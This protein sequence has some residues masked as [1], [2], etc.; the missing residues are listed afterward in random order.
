[1][2]RVELETRR[3]QGIVLYYVDDEWDN[4]E[5]C[6]LNLE[7]HFHIETER[8]SEKALAAIEGGKEI[9]VLLTDQVMPKVTGMQLAEAMKR[10]NPLVPCIMITGHATKDLAIGAIKGRLFYD[11]LEKPVDFSTRGIRNILTSAIQEFLL[12]KLR[13]EY[14]TGSVNLLAR[15]IDERDGYTHEHSQRVMILSRQ[16]A[17]KFDLP[18]KDVLRLSQAALLHDVGKIGIPDSVLRKEGKLSSLEKDVMN[19]HPERGARLV[20]QIEQLKEIADIIRYH[21]ECP[22]GSGYPYGLKG[23]RIPLLSAIVHAC[24]FFDAL[25]SDRPYKKGWPVDQIV[26]EMQAQRDQK[27]NGEVLDAFYAVMIDEKMLDDNGIRAALDQASKL[28]RQ[29]ENFGRLETTTK[30]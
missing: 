14:E 19:S 30:H 9:H 2:D 29:D 1:M 10:K 26:R 7:P 18:E 12:R 28:G 25:A 15:V 5:S 20:S 6:T 22:D 27:F 8:D 13:V 17:Q 3:Y 24:D 4:L 21:H 11:F 16:V 23:E